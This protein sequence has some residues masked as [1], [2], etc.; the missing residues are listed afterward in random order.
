[1]KPP[2]LIFAIA[3]LIAGGFWARSSNASYSQAQAKI[4]AAA[5]ANQATTTQLNDLKQYVATHSG[6]TVTVQLTSAYNAAVR[7]VEAEAATIATPD[8]SV[9]AAAQAAC[10]GK[11][12]S[13]VQAECNAQYL[14]T[15]A[16]PSSTT[17]APVQ[18]KLSDYTY[19]FVAPVLTFDFATILWGLAFVAI[20][21]L[22]LPVI[23]PTPYV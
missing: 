17:V 16:V 6:S 5:P 18:P 21:V 9:Y 12:I 19:H 15:H 4:L 3:V 7:Q 8:S 2:V 23:R 11:T 10:S 20:L 22:C 1:M 13:T 14:Q